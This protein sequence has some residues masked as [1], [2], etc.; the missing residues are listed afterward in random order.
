ME[1]F[2][3]NR[4]ML[5]WFCLCPVDETATKWTKFGY[6]ITTILTILPL[7]FMLITSIIYFL[8][9]FEIDLEESLYGFFQI[10]GTLSL[11]YGFWAVLFSRNKMKAIFDDLSEIYRASKGSNY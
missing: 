7:T 9:Y 11:L 2:K 10:G 5:T 6:I 4:K 1:P 8:K 3:T